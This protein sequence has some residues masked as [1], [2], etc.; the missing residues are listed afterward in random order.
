M[1]IGA[2]VPTAAYAT[3]AHPS[4]ASD[5]FCAAGIAHDFSAWDFV[6]DADDFDA[7]AQDLPRL[8]EPL[9]PIAQQWDGYADYACYMLM[10]AG[11]IKVDLILPDQ[12]Q[13][14]EPPARLTSLA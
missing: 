2:K 11:A 5:G 14:W 6:V 8:V 10:L 4:C 1:D 12:P 7:V 9:R 13:E 3:R